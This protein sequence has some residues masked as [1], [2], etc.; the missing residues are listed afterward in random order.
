MQTFAPAARDENKTRFAT[1][2]KGPRQKRQRIG[3]L[4]PGHRQKR[5]MRQALL[6]SPLSSG[7]LDT[8][9]SGQTTTIDGQDQLCCLPRYAL[10]PLPRRPSKLHLTFT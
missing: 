2:Y 4:S 7:R 9:T 10:I 6:M 8:E 5:E 1:D 3:S